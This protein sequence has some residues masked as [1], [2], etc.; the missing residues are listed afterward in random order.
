MRIATAHL[1]VNLGGYR[2]KEWVDGVIVGLCAALAFYL[3]LSMSS[4][5]QSQICLAKTYR[6]NPILPAWRTQSI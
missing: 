2:D 4:Q 1:R 3:Y 5:T 6:T